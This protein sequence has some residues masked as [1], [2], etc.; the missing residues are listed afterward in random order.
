[1][2]RFLFIYFLAMAS[3]FPQGSR[4][5]V[6]NLNGLSDVTLT[7]P[8]NGQALIYNSGTSQ[9]TN[10]VLPGGALSTLTDVSIVTPLDNQVLKYNTA[11]SKWLNSGPLAFTDVTGNIAVSQMNNGSG[12]DA[13]TYWRG[14]NSWASPPT[15]AI[16]PT[17]N[18]LIGDNA[19][20]AL[21][22]GSGGLTL[23][24]TGLTLQLD[25]NFINTLTI[26]NA[27][28]T[29]GDT[30]VQ[31]RLTFNAGTGSFILGKLGSNFVTSGIYSASDGYLQTI[32]AGDISLAVPV[33]YF[34]KF[35]NDGG[36]T[37]RVRIGSGIMAGTTTDKGAGT[38]N[39]SGAYYVNGVAVSNTPVSA[40]TASASPT[41]TTSATLVMM[42]LAAT[43]TPA[44]SGKV[45]M[46]LS[47]S[48]ANSATTGG[49]ATRLC[50]GTGAAPANGAAVTGT[51]VGGTAS[52][53]ILGV[54][55]AVPV[56][57]SFIV[58][59][60]TVGTTYWIDAALLAQTAGTASLQ[61]VT[62]SAFELQ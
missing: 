17:T 14:D 9:W 3:V 60:M 16:T 4:P 61:N 36:T 58:S 8:A 37:E 10:Q 5:P 38:V 48:I 39:V 26:V 13:T 50:Y 24:A 43:I 23:G 52:R 56:S 47:G 12:A 2:K 1:M 53:G 46:T 62:I 20:N 54:T 19:G 45:F 49:A 44:V 21:D 33:T 42:G 11:S 7:S 41:G 6:T 27:D 31:S 18:L 51:Q 30:A 28:T 59:T 34:L 15:G 29:G 55:T 25:G 22:A 57:L 40:Q 35:S 32:T